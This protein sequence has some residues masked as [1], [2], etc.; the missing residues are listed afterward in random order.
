MSLKDMELVIKTLSSKNLHAQ[1]ASLVNSIKDLI[2]KNYQLYKKTFKNK[3]KKKHF[4]TCFVK[5]V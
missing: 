5:S 3:M 1:M 2:K 4:P